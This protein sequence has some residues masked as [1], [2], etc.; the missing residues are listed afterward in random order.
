P[1]AHIALAAIFTAGAVAL[2]WHDGHYP[3][4]IHLARIL[5]VTAVVAGVAFYWWPLL[6]A[7][8]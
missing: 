7:R 2:F 3:A 1:G 5:S 4:A 8:R 6:R